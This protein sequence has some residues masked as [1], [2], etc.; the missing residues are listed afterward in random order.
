MKIT[1]R[2]GLL[3]SIISVLFFV[4]TFAL[5]DAVVATHH[6][7]IMDDLVDNLVERSE[8][9]F[10]YAII[11][12][13]ELHEAD[14]IDCDAASIDALQRT[15]FVSGMVKDI[16]V[17]RD[18][19]T[20][21]T[22]EAGLAVASD[23]AIAK[24]EPARN[25]SISIAAIEIDGV[26]AAAL[27]WTLSE[28]ISATAIVNTEA[29]VFDVLPMEL[30]YAG[31][32][33]LCLT[34]GRKIGFY[35][36][37]SAIGNPDFNTHFEAHSSRYPFLTYIK[38]SSSALA[39]YNAE[40]S[41]VWVIVAAVASTALALLVT[42]GIEQPPSP[43]HRIR[44]ALS[45]REIIPYFQPSFDLRTR[46]IVG[47]EVLARWR[48]KDGTLQSPATFI[49]VIEADGMSDMLLQ[50]MILETGRQ[51]RDIIDLA[52]ETSFAFNVTPSQIVDPAFPDMLARTL[53][54]A[55]MDPRSV[56]IEITEREIISDETAAVDHIAELARLGIRTAIDDAGTGHNGLAAIHRLGASILKIDKLFIDSVGRDPRSAALIQM[57]VGVAQDYG[58]RTVAEGIEDADQLAALGELGVDEA[59]GFLL[60]EPADA[61]TV[62]A[63]F[64]R[65]RVISLSR[66]TLQNVVRERS[67]VEPAAVSA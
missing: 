57:L 27:T 42:R 24:G 53:E 67:E 51:M 65:N 41:P 48:G 7:N 61:V 15:V 8:F 13:G 37:N 1:L 16:V 5:R 46:E 50:S 43:A 22:S 38:V 66:K 6:K 18:G 23:E 4:C 26:P 60:A 36:D 30:R 44:R 11:K 62:I 59:Q 54:E 49:P 21:S 64:A 47:F 19:R 17:R 63:D 29:L 14:A 32:V 58:M 28:G 40:F 10:D 52:P 34:G 55:G 25:R 20:C 9:A 35:P 56:I 12:L 31:K 33:A 39:A 3:A 45:R 2:T